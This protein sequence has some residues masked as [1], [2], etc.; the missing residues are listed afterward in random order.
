VEW[1]VARTYSEYQS[2]FIPETVARAR[3]KGWKLTILRVDFVLGH[4]IGN[5]EKITDLEELVEQFTM[6]SDMLRFV[7]EEVTDP[8]QL[9]LTT[10]ASE[11]SLFIKVVT[12]LSNLKEWQKNGPSSK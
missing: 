2:S 7:Q 8:A 10:Q 11:G 4:Q 1:K 6:T 12:P 3:E 5:L 9:T